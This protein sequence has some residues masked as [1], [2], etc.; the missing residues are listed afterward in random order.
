[1]TDLER[2]TDAMTTRRY[3]VARDREDGTREY[4]CGNSPKAAE[5]GP[6]WGIFAEAVRLD[7]EEAQRWPIAPGEYLLPLRPKGAAKGPKSPHGWEGLYW[8]ARVERDAARLEVDAAVSRAA[9][10]FIE[11]RDAARSERDTM[12]G[13][14]ETAVEEVKRLQA[15]DDGNARLV[16]RLTRD[17]AGLRRELAEA[18]RECRELQAFKLTHVEDRKV[19]DVIEQASA[20]AYGRAAKVCDSSELFNTAKAIRALAT[21]PA[22]VDDRDDDS[23]R[24]QLDAD[25]H[26][27]IHAAVAQQREADARIVDARAK[28]WAARMK[29]DD[30]LAWEARECAR[31]I[32]AGGTPTVETKCGES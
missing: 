5:P 28:D 6:Q 16:L 1:V 14:W 32:R 4:Y 26:D 22:P 29:P 9:I 31:A 19:G 21:T 13:R 12:R 11:E 30:P 25:V 18:R 24:D 2:E 3:V 8:E 15:E 20:E 27:A 10:Q 7:R 17:A 23:Y